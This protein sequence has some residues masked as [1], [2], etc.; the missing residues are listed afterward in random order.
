MDVLSLIWLEK[1]LWTVS[2][3][4]LEN[5]I[6][7]NIRE[8][9]GKFHLYIIKIWI[10]LE[11]YLDRNKNSIKFLL[12][13]AFTYMHMLS[14]MPSSHVSVRQIWTSFSE[15]SKRWKRSN[16]SFI[17][18]LCLPVGVHIAYLGGWVGVVL[19]RWSMLC[20]GS[21]NFF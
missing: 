15:S 5:K 7:F 16:L 21:T 17:G 1:F 6:S 12:Q 14:P 8:L 3:I 2:L 13:F 19:N 11:N 9:I 18:I 20:C 10:W 4:G